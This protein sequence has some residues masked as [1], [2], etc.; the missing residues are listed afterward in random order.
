MLS[1][2]L[3]RASGGDTW[4]P[5]GSSYLRNWIVP[6]VVVGGIVA[7]WLLFGFPS[8]RRERPSTERQAVAAGPPSNTAV[9][10]A[11]G[12]TARTN[13]GA[14]ASVAASVIDAADVAASAAVAAA[15]AA[16]MAASTAPSGRPTLRASRPLVLNISNLGAILFNP[17]LNS[18]LY[19]SDS[20]LVIPTKVTIRPV[21]GGYRISLTSLFNF[22]CGLDFDQG[23]NPRRLSNCAT[24]DP[25]SPVCRQDA[26]HSPC[27]E[28]T[29]GCYH[30]TYEARP[31]CFQVWAVKEPE[32]LLTC[33]S[34]KGEQA[35]KGRYTISN[36]H[37]Y[38]SP[39]EL[40]I[41]RHLP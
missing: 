6:A 5:S 3:R 2:K 35:C 7:Y 37:G 28:V 38:S 18:A 34:R 4:L 19:G 29:H 10:S 39:D 41:A 33:S 8:I 25:P 11:E 40:T 22:E 30:V 15:Y 1:S 24:K 36:S 20:T 23:G 16:S 17:W 32:V 27:V 26:P 21:T 9:S 31:D 14:A 13:P 12:Q